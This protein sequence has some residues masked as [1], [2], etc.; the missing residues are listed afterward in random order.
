MHQDNTGVYFIGLHPSLGSNN[1]IKQRFLFMSFSFT[2]LPNFLLS[3]SSSRGLSIFPHTTSLSICLSVSVYVCLFV[4][5]SLF[6]SLSSFYPFVS[7]APFAFIYLS[8]F[9][10]CLTVCLCF[11]IYLYLPR[12]TSLSRINM[13]LLYILFYCSPSGVNR[14]KPNLFDFLFYFVYKCPSPVVLAVVV[15]VVA[16]VFVAVI[17]V[18]TVVAFSLLA[19]YS[20]LCRGTI[21]TGCIA[22]RCDAQIL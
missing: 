9:F 6:L 7:F 4:C 1:K 11:C 20:L 19:L 13:T 16:E 18:T 10:A 12:F 8:F 5:L 17:A 3:Y 22:G 2:S 21:D 14:K 15:I